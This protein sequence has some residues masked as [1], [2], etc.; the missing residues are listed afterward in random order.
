MPA[1]AIDEIAGRVDT[2]I[3]RTRPLLGGNCLVRGMTLY[4][5]LGR[6]GYPVTLEFG[7]GDINGKLE[8]HCWLV[9]DD[10]PILENRD[11]RGVF[12]P[13][14]SIPAAESSA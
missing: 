1:L 6:M 8:G 2:V 9:M 11:P 12:R 7:V 5:F 13:I 14:F 3:N 10:L 4:Y